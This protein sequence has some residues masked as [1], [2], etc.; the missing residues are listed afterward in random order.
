MIFYQKKY[1]IYDVSI[2]QPIPL[3]HF[4]D[5]QN[6]DPKN[7]FFSS[8]VI[9]KLRECLKVMTTLTTRPKTELKQRVLF[10]IN[11]KIFSVFFLMLKIK[12]KIK[13]NFLLI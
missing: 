5:T 10:K 4:F 1:K 9:L 2:H 6:L 7:V 8:K 3:M 12:Y 13:I 11:F